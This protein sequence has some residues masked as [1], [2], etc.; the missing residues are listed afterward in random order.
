[1]KLPTRKFSA[2]LFAPSQPWLDA[3]IEEALDELF[4]AERD[5]ITAGF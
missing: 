3:I 5:N 1:M 2:R 4:T